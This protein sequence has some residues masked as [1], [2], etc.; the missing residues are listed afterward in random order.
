MAISEIHNTSWQS[1]LQQSITD[2]DKLCRLLA[3][4][5]CSVRTD[6][7]LLVPLPFAE[8]MERG[9]PNDPLLLQVLPKAEENQT[10]AGFSKD[11]LDEIADAEKGVALNKYAGRTLL[12]V[13]GECGIHCRFCFRRHFPKTPPKTVPN[14]DAETFLAP[15]RY[16]SAT[17]EVILSGG[18]P[19][20]LDDEVLNT[21]LQS[22][23]RLKH[24]RRIRI[25]SRLPVVLPNRLTPALAEILTLP[26]PVYLVLHVNHP[27]ELS[28]GF[29]ERRELLTKPAVMAQTVLLRGIND[30]VETLFQLFRRLIDARIMP[31]YLHQLDRVEGAVHFEVSSE[32]GL[33]MFAE[34]RRRL[35]GYAVP[36]YVREISGN[37]CKEVIA[38]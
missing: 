28:T 12:L 24:I 38:E 27:R 16:A 18:D 26:V 34:L 33:R 11:P 10:V 5:S 37:A 8:L 22:I 36:L 31:Y 3:I 21:L 32:A 29:L 13:S 35:P 17:E 4:P 6:Y 7:P 25:H 2:V 23:L 14:F 19:L 20:M 9:N 30:D 15:I 1:E